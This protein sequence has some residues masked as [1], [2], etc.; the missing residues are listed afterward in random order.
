MNLKSCLFGMLIAT[1]TMGCSRSVGNSGQVYAFPVANLEPAWI[2]NGEPIV[3]EESQWYPK[4][5]VEI[6]RDIEMIRLGEYKGVSFFVPK[7]DIHPYQRLYTKFGHNQFRY[8][9]KESK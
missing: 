2:R 5:D 3:F 1:I 7:I 9:L 4:S 8:Y 6:F